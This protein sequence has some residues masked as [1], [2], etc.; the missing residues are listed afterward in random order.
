[1]SFRSTGFRLKS[2]IV[3]VLRRE[4]PAGWCIAAVLLTAQSFAVDASVTIGPTLEGGLALA[5]PDARQQLYVTLTGADGRSQDVTRTVAYSVEPA[6]VAEVEPSGVVRPLR[7][8]T[9]TVTARTP[10]GRASS[11]M[12]T[13]S[14]FASPAP[15]S[16]K[17]QI[18]P[19]FTKLGCN[20]GGCHG[21][22]GGQ[23]GFKLSL[24][25]FHPE[26]DYEY[27]V[28][29]SRGRR[30]FP[31][32]PDQSLLIQKAVGRMPHGGGKRL[33]ANGDEHR[34][35]V[36]WIEQGMQFGSDEDPTVVSIEC[37]PA[38]RVMDRRKEQQ[39][40]VLARY[41]DG[42]VVDVT[43]SALY[44]AN[45]TEMAEC[46]PTG[47]VKT[48]DLAGEV[49]IMA[50]YQGHVATFRATIPLGAPLA[51]MPEPANVVDEAVFA[52]LKLLGIPP[53]E[54]CD[55]ATFLRRVSIDVAGA[56][57]TAAEVQAFLADGDPAKRTRL[58]E[59]LL[60]SPEYADLFANKWNMILRN[61]RRDETDK[62]G[63]YAFHRWIRQSLEKNKPYDEFVSEILTASGSVEFNPAVVWYREVDTV[64]EQVED[65]GQLFLGLRLQCARC[66]HHPYEKW[67]QN[68]YYGMAAFFS[69]VGRKGL[70]DEAATV[71]APRDRRI[72]H[73]EGRAA[74]KNPRTGE[75]LRPTGL[76]ATPLD[77]PPEA[78]PR[79][80]LA[81]WMTDP[82]NP[83]F[84][85]SLVNRYWKHF[86]G[87]GLV[88]P[89]DDMRATNPP[90][91]PEL[92]DAL[93]RSFADSGY[94]LKGLVRT[95][96]L[97]KTYQL[98][99]N[100]N[101]RN[102]DDKQ[103]F[104]RSYPKRLSA[105][106]L[107]DA[108]HQVTATSQSYAGLPAGT[109]ALQL[110]DPTIGPYFLKVFGQPQADTACECERSQEA[111][112]AQSLH[113]L[114]SSEVQGKIASDTGRAAQLAADPRP[115]EVKVSEL[116]LWV[117]GRLPTPD[118]LRVAVAH[119]TG[120]AEG[121]RPAYEDVVWALVN[122]KEFLF[123]H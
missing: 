52:K 109:R 36:R 116:Y 38:G 101:E 77:L 68:D 13:V 84:A 20:G 60:D 33:E 120:K 32:A 26:D 114:N 79:L 50:R 51:E 24:L 39:I 23:N 47:L 71:A 86:F 64:E 95:I 15:I 75:E 89:E 112:L 45:I 96:V 14:G 118:E 94:D 22:S 111:N 12:I 87:R 119:I 122:T 41:S 44:E 49:A 93:A 104:S 90:S 21:K 27:L 58:V 19:I 98:S 108:F 99:S 80:A 53:S 59:R 91:N 48:L 110:P 17:N 65:A 83:L 31:A 28:K 67:S 63:T 9:A 74:A 42:S 102:A 40:A 76:G 123:N 107:F 11:A 62:A 117:Y 70:P 113:L 82:S 25:G 8:G 69:R 30:L 103:N 5:N 43:R 72:F 54:P 1:M 56:L 3:G 106:V 73:D 37:H 66:H 18:V 46:S 121:P 29:E 61:K 7:D 100:P 6:G 85:K 92:L 35:L 34:L 115:H 55:D 88:E 16:F 57:P 10:E 105:E 97:S 2:R 4:S 81:D 78:D